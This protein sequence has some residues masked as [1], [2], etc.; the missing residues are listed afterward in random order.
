MDRSVETY[1]TKKQP[2]NRFVFSPKDSYVLIEDDAKE[3]VVEVG[4]FRRMGRGSQRKAVNG[5]GGQDC[6]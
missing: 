1:E 5:V 4:A 2:F 3:N 6:E